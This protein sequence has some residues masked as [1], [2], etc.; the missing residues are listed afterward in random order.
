VAEEFARAQMFLI[1]VF[2]EVQGH[3]ALQDDEHAGAR[4]AAQEQLLAGHDRPRGA[5]LREKLA[6]AGRQ[7]RGCR[8]IG[9]FFHRTAWLVASDQRYGL[10]IHVTPHS[11]CGENHQTLP[12]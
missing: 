9:H 2:A 7:H 10:R 11:L 4:F 12:Q 6:L 3:P 8:I 1:E 5:E